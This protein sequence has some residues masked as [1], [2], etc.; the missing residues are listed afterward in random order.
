MTAPPPPAPP[1]SPDTVERFARLLALLDDPFAD[2]AALLGAESLDDAGWEDTVRRYTALLGT[3]D[4]AVVDGFVAAYQ[5]ARGEIEGIHAA[6]TPPAAAFFGREAQPWRDDAARVPLAGEG[7]APP[8]L[9]SV[10]LPAD[11]D[12]DPDAG[13]L[14]ALRTIE[15]PV[16]VPASGLPFVA[17]L[18][19]APSEPRDPAEETQ[20]CPAFAS[21]E[22]PVTPFSDP[23]SSPRP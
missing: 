1:P 14:L 19:R 21:P 2:R 16:F 20:E 13:P 4:E 15:A 12:R 6:M 7:A 9:V 17:A 18:R 3:C 11:T 5:R 10:E 8:L 23:P 22:R